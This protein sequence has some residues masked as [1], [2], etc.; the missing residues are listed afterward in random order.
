M[1]FWLRQRKVEPVERTEIKPR[2]PPLRSQSSSFIRPRAILN[3][4]STIASLRLNTDSKE[5]SEIVEVVEVPIRQKL[6]SFHISPVAHRHLESEFRRLSHPHLILKREKFAEFLATVQGEENIRLNKARYRFHEFCDIIMLYYG[7]DAIQRP[8]SYKKD[9]SKP[10]THYFINSSHN[11]YLCGN[12]FTST[13]SPEPYRTALL[14]GCRCIEIDVLNG[15]SPSLDSK[16]PTDHKKTVS[17][18]SIPL[19]AGSLMD[20]VEETIHSTRQF[21]R[22]HSPRPTRRR[23]DPNQTSDSSS[24]T[25]TSEGGSSISLSPNGALEKPVRGRSLLSKLSYPKTEPIVAHKWAATR[26]CGFREV[27]KAIRESAFQTTQLPVIVSLEVLA[28]ED[29]QEVMVQIMK[30]EWAGLLLSEPLEG[31][32]PK[33]HAPRLEDLKNKI[34]IKVKKATPKPLGSASLGGLTPGGSHGDSTDDDRCSFTT[35]TSPAMESPNPAD[36]GAKRVAIC[37]NLSN[38]SIYTFSQSFKGF[39]NRTTKKPGHIFSISESRIHELVANNP[40]EI[41]QHNKNFLMRAFPDGTRVNSSNPDPSPFWRQGVQMVAMNRQ[42]LDEGMILNEGMFADEEGWVLKPKGYGVT[43][44]GTES[45]HDAVPLTT[46]DLKIS[47]LAG[48][49]I[50]SADHCEDDDGKDRRANLRPSVKCE[51]QYEKCDTRKGEKKDKMISQ[52]VECKK[53]TKPSE[54]DHPDFG[55]GGCSFSF[56]GI[57]GTLQEFVFIR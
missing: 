34:L 18:E 24:Q 4:L 39:D 12:Q 7:F 50:C 16:K 54:T 38:L 21:I 44:K 26:P 25:Q 14:R 36:L 40:F 2:R 51:L 53:K 48:Q 10:I 9:L 20:K 8:L 42:N 13:S 47:I 27:C 49:K 31:C 15:D 17:H 11:T 1:R 45:Y 37:R 22:D 41:F 57:R 3:R 30:E 28:D 33:F 29:Q 43:D 32:D 55:E 35:K 46:T 56:E 19:L 5:S 52:V 6:P 23:L